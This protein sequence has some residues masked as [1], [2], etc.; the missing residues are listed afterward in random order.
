MYGRWR[1]SACGVLRSL[2]TRK[3]C[4]AQPVSQHVQLLCAVCQLRLPRHSHRLD[5]PEGASL[6]RSAQ[7]T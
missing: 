1:I 5:K 6:H 3:Q 4:D 7:R 2:R